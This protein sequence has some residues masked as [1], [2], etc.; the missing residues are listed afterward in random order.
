MSVRQADFEATYRQL[1]PRLE[2]LVG[3]AVGAPAPVIEEACQVAWSQLVGADPPIREEVVLSW[4]VTTAVRAAWRAIKRQRREVSLDDRDGPLAEV[5]EL[6]APG[7]GPDRVAELREQLA[8]IHYLPLR[9]R[10]LVW[11]Q[12]LGFRYTEI[13]EITGD[14]RRAVERQLLRA[15]R[16]LSERVA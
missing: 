15:K 13:A 9:Q 14:S 2:R 7:P 1:G 6:P 12:S 5:I 16:T 10:R 8:E 3:H 11:L 4:L